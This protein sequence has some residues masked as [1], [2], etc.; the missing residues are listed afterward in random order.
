MVRRAVG[1]RSEEFGDRWRDDTLNT[2]AAAVDAGLERLVSCVVR[3]GKHDRPFHG[4]SI[5]W[6]ADQTALAD[7]DRRAARGVSSSVDPMSIERARVR[8]R[9]VFGHDLLEMW[10]SELFGEPRFLMFALL[11]RAPSLTRSEFAQYWWDEHRPLVNELIPP[12]MQPPIYVHDYVAPG[13]D[14]RWDGVGEF[15]DDSIDVVRERTQF[16]AG[17]SAI[18]VDEQHFLVDD[19]RLILLTDATVLV[20]A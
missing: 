13:E 15:Y 12:A 1:V 14:F 4:V 2:A 5:E 10:W 8:A 19:T 18:L 3:P 7:H 16:V 9:T 11:E 6:F 17:R 20:T